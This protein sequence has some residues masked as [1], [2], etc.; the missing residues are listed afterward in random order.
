MAAVTELR[1]VS[2]E[3]GSKGNAIPTAA[4]AVVTV[5]DGSAARKAAETLAAELKREYR[6]GG[7]RSD[8]S[9]GDG[10]DQEPAHGRGD[11]R[12]RRFAC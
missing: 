5:A 6:I 9:C 11:H 4:A 12:A 1:L 2:A 3:G 10:G 8:G 7:S